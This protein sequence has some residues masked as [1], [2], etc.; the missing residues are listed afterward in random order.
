MCVS[1]HCDLEGKDGDQSTCNRDVCVCG[2]SNTYIRS[3]F[4]VANQPRVSIH[5][6][7]REKDCA[8]QCVSRERIEN[9]KAIFL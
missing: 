7:M 9:A 8:S 3:I 1:Q 2:I 4:E 5:V 6:L